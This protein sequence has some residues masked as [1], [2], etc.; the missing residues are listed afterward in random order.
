MKPNY[1]LTQS[2]KALIA[3]YGPMFANTGGNDIIE[4]IERPGVNF[5]NNF[6]VASLQ[7]ACISQ[8]ILLET[9]AAEGLL[10]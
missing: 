10:K 5:Q 9:L 3:L 1:K 4:L 2:Q 6:V 7:V 8:V